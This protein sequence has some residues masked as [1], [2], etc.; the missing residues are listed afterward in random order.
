MVFGCHPIERNYYMEWNATGLVDS[1]DQKGSFRDKRGSGL[2]RGLRPMRVHATTHIDC[3][4]RC[5]TSTFTI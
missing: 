2:F 3:G 5:V 1:W 4:V